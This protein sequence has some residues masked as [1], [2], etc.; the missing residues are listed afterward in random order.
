VL[1]ETGVSHRLFQ[2]VSG[3]VAVARPRPFLHSLDLLYGFD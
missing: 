2:C 1:S 3:P